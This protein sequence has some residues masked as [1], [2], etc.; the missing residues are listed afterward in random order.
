MWHTEVDR[1]SPRAPHPHLTCCP[2]LLVGRGANDDLVDEDPMRNIRKGRVPDLQLSQDAAGW[3]EIVFVCASREQPLGPFCDPVF[4]LPTPHSSGTPTT[5]PF[6]KAFA[7]EMLQPS[8]GGAPLPAS[9]TV[10]NGTRSA[11]TELEATN[12][13]TPPPSLYWTTYCHRATT[14]IPSLCA[15]PGDLQLWILAAQGQPANC[16]AA[17]SEHQPCTPNM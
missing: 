2:H 4:L 16:L 10:S 6:C 14:Q 17:M 8:K 3:K 15:P 12:S 13:P 1:G 5:L 11:G 7:A 9:S